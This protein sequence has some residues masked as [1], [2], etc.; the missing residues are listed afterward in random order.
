MTQI[1]ILRRLRILWHQSFWL[2]SHLLEVARADSVQ[3]AVILSYL[4]AAAFFNY[5]FTS[6]E[7]FSRFKPGL[8]LWDNVWPRIFFNALPFVFTGLYLTR[9]KISARAK[10]L[11][12]IFS[13][14]IILHLASWC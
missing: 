12:W 6:I 4:F 5:G 1:K 3:R 13:F 9:S 7:I 11:V 14:S 10:I 2:P 8:T